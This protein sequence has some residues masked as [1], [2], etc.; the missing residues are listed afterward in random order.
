MLTASVV[1]ID[2]TDRGRP[3]IGNPDLAARRHRERARRR[4]NC[5]LGQLLVGAVSKALTESLSWLTTHKLLVARAASCPEIAGF[6]AVER[7]MDSC[8]KFCIC[9]MPRSS[10]AVTVSQNNERAR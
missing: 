10:L 8:Q 9:S 7:Q 4:P 1:G 2:D 6:G 5:D 3:S